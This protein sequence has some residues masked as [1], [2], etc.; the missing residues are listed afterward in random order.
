MKNRC[1]V[2]AFSLL[3]LLV[4]VGLIGVLSAVVIGD[5][6]T[7]GSAR[8][9]QSAQALLFNLLASA[10]TTAMASGK[11]SRVLVQMDAA[12][13]SRPSRY[14]RYLALQIQTPNGWQALTEMSL[15]EGVFVVPGNLSALPAGLFSD[16]AESAWTKSD[17]TAL[18]STAL[19]ENQIV[20][21]TIAAG[22]TE[23]WASII[24]APSGS[25]NQAGDIILAIGQLRSPASFRLG[26]SPV[27]LT[28]AALV[29][30]VSLSSYG[31]PA[32]IHDRSGF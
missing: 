17:G 16:A 10:R 1:L 2:A 19:R 28:H 8:A 21:E 27:A 12:N 5:K 31:V 4:V 25:T 24:L 6:G 22:V 9:L 30:G 29:R 23:Q 15:P 20:S 13:P 14:L 11:S 26:E 18:R 3:E 7:R 32:L